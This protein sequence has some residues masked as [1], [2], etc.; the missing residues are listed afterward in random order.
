M[1][2][3]RRSITVGCLATLCTTWAGAPVSA[4]S[5]AQPTSAG[6]AGLRAA[7]IAWSTAF[8][9]GSAADIRKMEGMQCRSGPTLSAAVVNAYLQGM[10]LELQHYLGTPLR[11]IRII[12]V[13]TRDVTSTTG[14]AEVKYDLPARVVGNDDWV[15]YAYQQRRWKVTNCHAPIG[16][17]S[18]SASASSSG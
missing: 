13:R 18:S 6:I 14:D 9:T 16:G 5:A 12:G 17:E 11:S 3:I 1:A 2:A 8:L 4:S 7:A 10:R 15:S